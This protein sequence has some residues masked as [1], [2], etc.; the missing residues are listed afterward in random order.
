MYCF[1]IEDINKRFVSILQKFLYFT[2]KRDISY[3]IA[4]SYFFFFS[5][6]LFAC[7]CAL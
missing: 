7:R 6:S 1:Y 4:I 2:S 3:V 5:L